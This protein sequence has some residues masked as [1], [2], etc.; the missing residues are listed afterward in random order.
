MVFEQR[1]AWWIDVAFIAPWETDSLLHIR[2]YYVKRD[3]QICQKRPKYTNSLVRNTLHEK[4]STSFTV[5][6]FV[7][8]CVCV[9]C[10]QKVRVCECKCGRVSVSVRVC[11][12]EC[13]RVR[14]H[15]RVYVCVWLYVCDCTCT[16]AGHYVRVC[17]CQFMCLS[18]YQ[19]VSVS[20]RVGLCVCACASTA[21]R[22]SVSMSV[23]AFGPVCI[24]VF[25]PSLIAIKQVFSVSSIR[26]FVTYTYTCDF[27]SAQ[28]RC[29]WQRTRHSLHLRQI[30]CFGWKAEAL[31]TRRCTLYLLWQGKS[32]LDV[33]VIGMNTI[34]LV[35]GG[36]S[37]SQCVADVCTIG[38]CKFGNVR[39]TCF[40][41]MA[42]K[43]WGW[44][45]QHS[46]VTL[47]LWPLTFPSSSSSSSHYRVSSG[48]HACT[49]TQSALRKASF[50]YICRVDRMGKTRVVERTS[51]WLS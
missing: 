27:T 4:C 35:W 5:C 42:R 28:K 14:V 9:W 43:R 45:F 50:Q 47:P 12:R 10:V 44:H 29:T 38:M 18:V 13:V 3:L 33:C 17:V 37:A 32:D 11:V 7:C 25:E 46:P 1:D 40:V 36:L 6:E 21:V 39:F 49:V 41:S 24:S 20:M 23:S 15:M 48:E 26:F 31:S 2:S 8:A 34:V 22:V 30:L 16:C 19:R 51:S